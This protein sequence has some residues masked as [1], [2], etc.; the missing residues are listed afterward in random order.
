M[1]LKGQ[2]QQRS[3]GSLIDHIG[4]SYEDLDTHLKQ[5]ENAGAKVLTQPHDVPGLFKVAFIEDPFGIKIEMV[6]DAGLTGFHHVHLSVAMPETTL[7]WYL[8]NAV[9]HAAMAR[10]RIVNESSSTIELSVES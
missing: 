5:A 1:F 4:I 3:A 9:D 7:R 8:D 2:E 10:S 6:Q